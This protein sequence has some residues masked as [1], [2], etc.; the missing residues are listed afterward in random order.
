MKLG[1]IVRP[2]NWTNKAH[3]EY[4]LGIIFE[5]GGY[6]QRTDWFNVWFWE[7]KEKMSFY[8]SQLTT[9]SEKNV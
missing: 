2:A 5:M 1:D 9:V 4:G 8:E 7:T 6:G 3:K